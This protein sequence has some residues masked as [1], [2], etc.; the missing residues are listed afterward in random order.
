MSVTLADVEEAAACLKGV[1][2]R[3]PVME[4]STLSSLA[5]KHLY[6]KCENFQRVG[7]FK[8]RGACNAIKHL[9]KDQMANGVVTHSSGNHAQALA[10]AAKL[11]GIPAHI[12]MPKG[13]PAVKVNA[14]KEYGGMVHFCE[15]NQAAREATCDS[16]AAETNAVFV[17]P[18]NNPYIIAGQG[19][20]ALELLHDVGELDAIVAPVG[21]GGLLSGT[22][23]A[24]KAIHPGI[25]IFGAE[26]VNADDA[27]RSLQ[28]GERI[29]SHASPPDTVC[30][31]LKTVLGDQTWPIIKD[32][33][34]S[35]ITVTE[36][37]IMEAMQ[38]VYERMKLV[39]EP[40]SATAIA[41]VLSPT[42][43]A[44]KDIKRVGIIISGG[45]VDLAKLNWLPLK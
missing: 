34:E 19:T 17:H 24:A 31:G 45:N 32:G 5:D 22:V 35:I 16:I 2:H 26:P 10:L 25:R 4:S 20:A 43:K 40:S 6:F 7:A 3:T 36:A 29:T 37:E 14:V 13:S 23:V 42:F 41:A 44:M 9:P 27:Q 11:N 18:Y 15:P 38:L 21:G 1:A 12:V 8:F 30:D 28:S 39:I 33:V